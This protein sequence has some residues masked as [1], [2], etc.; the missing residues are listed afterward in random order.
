MDAA[1]LP[2]LTHITWSSLNI[3]QF[4]AK[5]TGVIGEFDRF[6]QQVHVH[7]HV[8]TYLQVVLVQV[9]MYMCTFV[10]LA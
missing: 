6:L 4:L 2:G 9:H 1:L 8:L 7:V 10:L 5:V 3:Q